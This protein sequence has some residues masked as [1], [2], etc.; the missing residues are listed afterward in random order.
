MP[1]KDSERQIKGATYWVSPHVERL[2]QVLQGAG[3][4]KVPRESFPSPPH[5]L[6]LVCCP[7]V[8]G[9]SAKLNRQDGAKP[10]T[11]RLDS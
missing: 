3:V 4:Y 11:F 9:K 8:H 10:P 5:H 6:L 7:K 2:V 1:R